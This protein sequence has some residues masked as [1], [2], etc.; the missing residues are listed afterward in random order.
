MTPEE[1]EAY[2][3]FLAMLKDP[4]AILKRLEP[5]LAAEMTDERRA[6]YREVREKW[7]KDNPEA[8]RQNDA[9]LEAAADN[10]CIAIAGW[11]C[12]PE[13]LALRQAE[14]A[15]TKPPRTTKQAWL[16]VVATAPE[17]Y[18][19]VALRNGNGRL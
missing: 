7:A 5:N 2:Q 17:L 3:K 19:D 12:R 16:E 9:R 14:R 11:N 1:K 13:E 4:D 18:S 6:R 10:A 8:L 15:A